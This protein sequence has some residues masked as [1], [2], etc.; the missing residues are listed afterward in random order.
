MVCPS[1]EWFENRPHLTPF[2]RL[3]W[4]Q[5]RVIVQWVC[6]CTHTHT[7]T[8]RERERETHTQRMN[9]TPTA[10]EQAVACAPV[11]QRAWIRSPVGTSF[12]GCDFSSPVRQISGS[13]RPPWFP[14]HHLA[15]II[16]LIIS[17]FLECMNYWMVCIVFNY[18]FV[19]S[20]RWPQHWANYSSV[21]ALHVLVW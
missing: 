5:K 11:T 17:T 2:F 10:V 15:I 7:H 9:N 16:I 8:Q 14:E 13:F 1:G 20:R 21:E 19:L 6:Y 12:P 3:A 18:L 4:N